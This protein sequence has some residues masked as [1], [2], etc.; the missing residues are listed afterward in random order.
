MVYDSARKKVILFG[1]AHDMT[2]DA[3][4]LGDTWAYDPAANRWTNLRPA[5]DDFYT[6]W[7]AARRRRGFDV[8]VY[9]G[10]FPRGD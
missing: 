10:P 7:C 1:G 5:G 8:H 6:T 9:H 2:T 4:C 3:D